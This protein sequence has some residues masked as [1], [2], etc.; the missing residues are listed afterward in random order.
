MRQ[1]FTFLARRMVRTG[2]WQSPTMVSASHRSITIEFSAYSNGC[3]VREFQ[4]QA[5]GWQSVSAWSN[6]TVGGFGSSQKRI[7]GRLFT[8]RFRLRKRRRHMQAEPFRILLVED[9]DA[10]VYLLRKALENAALNFELIVI[11]DGAEA[12]AYARSEGKYSG[13][14]RP[15]AA[16]LDMN[17]PK[18]EGTEVL[19]ALRR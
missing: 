13:A 4:G 17:L 12:L 9:N 3:T 2:A 16:V 5:L 15:D 6:V 14:A 11:D 1:R 19:E 7:K 10:D 18:S 8:S